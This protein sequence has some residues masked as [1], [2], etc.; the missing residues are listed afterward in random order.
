MHCGIGE[1][2]AVWVGV[3]DIVQ[4]GYVVVCA[5]SGMLLYCASAAFSSCRYVHYLI[6]SHFFCLFPL[7]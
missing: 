1:E 6:L 2:G 4:C 7:H 5:G 3:T